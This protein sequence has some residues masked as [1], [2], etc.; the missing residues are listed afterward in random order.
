MEQVEEWAVDSILTCPDNVVDSLNNILYNKAATLSGCTGFSCQWFWP[1]TAAVLTFPDRRHGYKLLSDR[2][3]VAASRHCRKIQHNVIT[4]SELFERT[5][6]VDCHPYLGPLAADADHVARQRHRHHHHCQL[7]GAAQEACQ[8]VHTQPGCRRPDRL[9]CR[10]ADLYSDGSEFRS[11]E[12]R[13][14]RLQADCLRVY[15]FGCIYN[16]SACC[17]EYRQISGKTC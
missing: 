4:T 10:D 1:L 16:F 9:L 17:Y 3:A 5:W 11:V 8:S 13:S 12:T 15:G 2:R 7:C 14:G 6:L